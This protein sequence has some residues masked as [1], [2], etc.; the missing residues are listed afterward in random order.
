[1]CPPPRLVGPEN[2]AIPNEVHLGYRQPL[3]LL[4]VPGGDV[5]EE[6]TPVAKHHRAAWGRAA[7]AERTLPSP[8]SGPACPCGST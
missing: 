3:V 1:M 8:S 6:V 2:L 4:A 7:D 5:V